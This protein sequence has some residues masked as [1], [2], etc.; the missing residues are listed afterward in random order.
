MYSMQH[1]VIKFVSDL[2]HV[3]GFLLVLWFLPPRCYCNIVES[4]VRHHNPNNTVNT[5][6]FELYIEEYFIKIFKS[7]LKGKLYGARQF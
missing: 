5:L 4:G 7:I 1:Y 2:R 6:F 3:G